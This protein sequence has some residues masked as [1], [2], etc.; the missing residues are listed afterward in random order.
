MSGIFEAFAGAT[1]GIGGVIANY[2]GQKEANR[3]NEEYSERNANLQEDVAYN[4]LG[5]RIA[6]AERNGISKWSVVGDG[7]TA[8]SI[9]SPNVQSAVKPNIGDAIRGAVEIQQMKLAT[10]KLKEENE[11]LEYQRRYAEDHAFHIMEFQNLA[12]L[13]AF[14]ILLII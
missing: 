7:A 14:F 4:G 10:D 13:L 5:I 3:I 8:G 2:I 11:N 6:D 1:A 12:C 9:S